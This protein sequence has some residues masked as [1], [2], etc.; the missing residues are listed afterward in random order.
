MSRLT[1]NQG[2]AL[3][4]FC[5]EKSLKPQLSSHPT[6][7]FTNKKGEEVTHNIHNIVASW[8]RMRK[9]QEKSKGGRR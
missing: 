6:Y 1:L 4:W 9:E 8:N 3:T 2:K 7:F 5:D